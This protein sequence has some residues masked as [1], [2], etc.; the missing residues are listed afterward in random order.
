M[1]I[2]VKGKLK[3]LSQYVFEMISNPADEKVLISLASTYSDGV[4]NAH[5]LSESI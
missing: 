1:E 4:E 5:H 2:K 3:N